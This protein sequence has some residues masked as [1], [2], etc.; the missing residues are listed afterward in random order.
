MLSR[1][2]FIDVYIT[3]FMSL[4]LACFVLAL[5]YPEQRRRYLLLMYVAIGLGVLTKGP[6]AI[7]AARARRAASGCSSSAGCATS[8]G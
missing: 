3:A 8:A 5:R 7:A 1:R 4:A 6:M 2:I